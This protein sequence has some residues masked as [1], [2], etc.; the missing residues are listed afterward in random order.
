M[1]IRPGLMTL[2][3]RQNERAVPPSMLERARAGQGGV[4]VG[5]GEAGIGRTALIVRV[6][7]AR[8]QLHYGE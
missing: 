5:R 3:D 7:P 1:S 6:D 2:R 4:L 8:A